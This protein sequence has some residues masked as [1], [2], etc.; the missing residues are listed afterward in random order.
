[1]CKRAL[2]LWL[3]CCAA[4]AQTALPAGEPV[5]IAQSYTFESKVLGET[6]RFNVMLPRGYDASADRYP[7]LLLLD[8]GINE[9]FH[10]LSGI[11]Q[12]SSDNGSM[13]PVIVVGVE[14]TERR[15]DTTGPTDNPADRK[16]APRVGGSA[17]FRRFLVE[18]LLPAVRS[19][20]RASSETAI[21]GESLAGLFVIETLLT[22]PEHFDA[23]IAVSPSL[24]WNRGDL[25]A[26]AA[27]LLRNPQLRG[28]RVFLSVAGDDEIDAGTAR[29]ADALS[30]LAP[31]RATLR[32]RPMPD[33]THATTL[34]PAAMQALHWV[35]APPTAA[36]GS[37]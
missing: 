25:V 18:E 11:V 21:G 6:R 14:N 20:Y 28:E 35:F 13:R 3:V 24:W 5:V 12:V 23:Y 33:E 22:A 30:K 4:Q 31:E 16:I 27:E 36:P 32:Y 26:H 34:H 1:M 2:V 8:G 37:H 10:H 17:A 15:R 9:D 19:R 29:L 7:V